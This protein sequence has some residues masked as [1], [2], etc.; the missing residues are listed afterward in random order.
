MNGKAL[1]RPQSPAATIHYRLKASCRYNQRI[2]PGFL[3]VIVIPI[4]VTVYADIV[5]RSR[6]NSKLPPQDQLSWWLRNSSKVS[7]KYEEFYPDSILPTL[8]E[9]GFW[10]CYIAGAALLVSRFWK[11]S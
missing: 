1:S 3:V 7:K 5:M 10:L 6:I 11:S 2:V 8:R 4:V 9:Y